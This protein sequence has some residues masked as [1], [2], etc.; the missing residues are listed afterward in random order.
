MYLDYSS[1]DLPLWDDGY[2]PESLGMGRAEGD[3]VK[4]SLNLRVVQIDHSTRDSY[5]ELYVKN[6]D[7]IKEIQ[8]AMSSGAD[9]EVAA[10]QVRSF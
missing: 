8:A 2:F 5:D 3:T 1:M 4:T 9:S 7:G 10:S 6:I